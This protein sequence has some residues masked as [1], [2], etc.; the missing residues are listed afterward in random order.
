MISIS[1]IIAEFLI[2]NMSF[3]YTGLGDNGKS[4]IL[5]KAGIDKFDDIFEAEGAL[6]ELNS[7]IG[8][9]A[10]YVNDKHTREMLKQIQNDLFIIGANLAALGNK[11]IK[12]KEFG[13]DRTAKLEQEIEEMSKSLPEPKQFIVPGGCEG[14]VHMHVARAIARKAERRVLR[15][16]KSYE[17]SS[18][19]KKY[20]NRLSTYLYV[21]ALYLN[22]LEGIEEQHPT[23]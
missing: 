3:Y 23:Y 9:T 16:T 13:E 4:G 10:Y 12:S 22:H 6:D 8:L 15:L 11:E 14:A 5:G 7:Y 19:I 17:I 20:L 1:F 21:A 2:Q 18:S